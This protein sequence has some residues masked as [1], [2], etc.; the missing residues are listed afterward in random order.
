MQPQRRAQSNKHAFQTELKGERAQQQQQH[1]VV[2][3][4][5][6]CVTKGWLLA[7][8]HAPSARRQIRQR[9]QHSLT[10]SLADFKAFSLL[11]KRDSSLV[12]AESGRWK[13]KKIKQNPKKAG[14]FFCA[15]PLLSATVI[16]ALSLL[17]LIT[18]LCG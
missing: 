18:L 6:R 4:S 1:S 15:S 16:V 13:R 12:W 11:S 14:P 10:H 8:A 7:A 17:P 5:N 2:T 3:I 9:D